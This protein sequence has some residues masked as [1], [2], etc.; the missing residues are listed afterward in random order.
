MQKAIWKICNY[1]NQISGNPENHVKNN[2]VWTSDEKPYENELF[3]Y[4]FTLILYGSLDFWKR[5]EN[6]FGRFQ[7]FFYNISCFWP[8]NIKIPNQNI[9]LA[10]T[11][12]SGRPFFVLVSH[13]SI[14]SRISNVECSARIS[15]VRPKF[16]TFGR[17]FERLAEIP[18]V[19]LQSRMSVLP[20]CLNVGGPCLDLLLHF[21]FFPE[22]QVDHVL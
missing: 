8:R 19:R 12:N 11:R 21:S 2:D 10:L 3:L 17:N 7:P 6:I 9:K 13:F 5:S 20:E 1:E 22:S 18:K 14:F 4:D 15:N 16:L